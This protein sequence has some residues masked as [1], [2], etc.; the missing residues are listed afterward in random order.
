MSAA[1]KRRNM[2]DYFL[3]SEFAKLR[4][5][6]INSLRYYEKLG[7]LRP[8]YIDEKTNYRYYLPEQISVLNKIIL[9][10]QLGIPLKEMAG[11]I[12]EDG[13][14]QS[15]KLLEQGK[16]LAQ[17]RIEEMQANLNYIEASLKSIEDNKKYADKQ[18]I[19]PRYFKERT[20]ITTEYFPKQSDVKKKMISEIAELYKTTQK[21]NFFPQLPA[22]QIVDVDP[23]GTMQYRCFFEVLN[24]TKNLPQLLTLPAGTYSCMQ[25]DSNPGMN[26]AEIIRKNWPEKESFTVIVDNVMLEKFS[27]KTRPSELQ[28]IP[29]PVE[30]RIQNLT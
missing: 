13:N 29:Q 6:N 17:K 28:I 14:L 30:N 21:N 11:M 19:Y 20:V 7:L 2:Q 27:F 3:I 16:L 10:V 22:G 25:L 23:S 5:I 15:Q 18:G 12:D 9:C 8:A 4:D 24:V 26:L 1:Q